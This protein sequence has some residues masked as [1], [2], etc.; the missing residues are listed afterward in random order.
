MFR[1]EVELEGAFGKYFGQVGMVTKFNEE[2]QEATLVRASGSQILGGGFKI[3]FSALKP[4]Q[5]SSE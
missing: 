1:V 4:F 2:T 5:E 3:P